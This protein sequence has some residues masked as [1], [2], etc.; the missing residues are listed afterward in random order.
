MVTPNPT[1]GRVA[2][3]FY[4]NPVFVKGINI[5][6]SLGRLVISQHVNGPGSSTYYFDLGKFDRGVYYVQVVLG[7]KVITQKVLKQ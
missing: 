2:V 5:F 3:Q 1:T 6:N 4:P 7:D